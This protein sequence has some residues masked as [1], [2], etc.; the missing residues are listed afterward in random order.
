MESPDSITVPAISD[1]VIPAVRRRRTYK[2]PDGQEFIESV[3]K[4]GYMI[5]FNLL[6]RVP[7]ALFGMFFS[8]LLVDALMWFE[9]ITFIPAFLSISANESYGIFGIL[10]AVGLVGFLHYQICIRSFG[11]ITHL[12]DHVARWFGG[13]GENL[14]EKGHTDRLVGGVTSRAENKITTLG[15][16]AA[17]AKLGGGGGDK[18]KDPS[19]EVGSPNNRRGGQKPSTGGAPPGGDK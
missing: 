8:F 13:S 3:Q 12:P 17:V 10:A 4:P 6:L 5:L 9:S 7:L 16:G 18:N 15:G 11:L 14:D 1:R 19:K 2:R